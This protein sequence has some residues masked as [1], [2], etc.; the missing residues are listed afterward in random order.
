M[1]PILKGEYP[2]G[3]RLVSSSQVSPRLDLVSMPSFPVVFVSSVWASDRNHISMA[4]EKGF[5]RGKI[6]SRYFLA[7]SP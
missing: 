4:G 1:S 3:M 2:L 6:E 7:E 5:D